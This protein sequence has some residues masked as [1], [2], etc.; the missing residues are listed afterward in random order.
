[1]QVGQV[2][3]GGEEV[4]CVRVGLSS[5]VVDSSANGNTHL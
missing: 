2:L 1:M 3:R 5:I 4:S